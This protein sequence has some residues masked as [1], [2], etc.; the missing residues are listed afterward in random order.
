MINVQPVSDKPC[1][2]IFLDID[3]VLNDARDD[4]ILINGKMNPRWSREKDKWVGAQLKRIANDFYKKDDELRLDKAQVHMFCR[5]SVANLNSLI[6]KIEAVA[7]VH[8]V[9]SSDWR[10]GHTVDELKE[11]FGFCNFSRFLIDKTQKND[12][13][14][15][16][17]W[18]NFCVKPHFDLSYAMCLV[19]KRLSSTFKET[20][21]QREVPYNERCRASEIK[22]YLH[23][24]P[25]YKGYVIFDDRDAHLSENFGDKFISTED[26]QILTSD[27][28]EKAY[29]V[30]LNFIENLKNGENDQ[31]EKVL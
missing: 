26:T 10:I 13:E 3:G 1:F 5:N 2:A 17:N 4:C 19:H 20:P 12:E 24:H 11:I 21:S 31:A 9:L 7:N 27:H 23:Y 15:Y 8:I 30:F 29:A 25:E 14:P 18:K 6:K 28:T 16:G 22:E